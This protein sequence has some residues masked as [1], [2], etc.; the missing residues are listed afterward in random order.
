M[1]Y[2]RKLM[3]EASEGADLGGGEASMLSSSTSEP[4]NEP[5]SE[6]NVPSWYYSAPNEDEGVE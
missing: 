6:G 5:S 2:F 1:K 4:N 3:E